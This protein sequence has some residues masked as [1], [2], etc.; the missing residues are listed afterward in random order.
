MAISDSFGVWWALDTIYGVDSLGLTIND[1][2]EIIPTVIL[3]Q[4]F[5]CSPKSNWLVDL[6]YM[7]ST[8][9]A[10]GQTKDCCDEAM[11]S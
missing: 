3:L 7:D 1:E 9:P 8:L 11:F 6:V 4:K 2:G 5:L 10:T